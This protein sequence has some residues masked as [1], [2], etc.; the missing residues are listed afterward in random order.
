MIIVTGATGQLGRGIVKQLLARTSADQVAVSVRDPEKA[1]DLADEGV[2]VRRGDFSDPGTLAP[3]FRDASQVLVT[4]TNTL[5]EEG[6]IQA[7]A[8]IDAAYHAGASRVLYTS[9]QAANPDSLFAPA[10]DHAAI[11]AHLARLGRPYTSLRNG[12]YMTSLQFHIADAAQTGELVAP[13]D[14]PVSWT[15]RDDLAEAAA[16]ILLDEGRFNGPT[17]PLISGPMVDL[18]DVA[19]TL[20]ELSG[21]TIRRVVVDDEDFVARLVQKGTPEHYARLLLGS[22]HAARRGEFAVTDPTLERLIE[23]PPITI[24]D[25]FASAATPEAH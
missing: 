24:R 15:A 22:F 20:S 25:F 6:V 18:G 5:G 14:G 9:H 8:A 23:R 19:A 7:R 4:S 21:R 17:P 13:A 1:A 12:Y 3:A 16:A 10:P 2:S 11:E